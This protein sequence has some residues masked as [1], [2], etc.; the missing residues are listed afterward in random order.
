MASLRAHISKNIPKLRL[1]ED[2]INHDA[3]NDITKHVIS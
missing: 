1:F 2:G 3:E